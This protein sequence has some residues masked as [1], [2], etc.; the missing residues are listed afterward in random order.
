MHG[1]G[2]CLDYLPRACGLYVVQVAVMTDHARAFAP[3]LSCCWVIRLSQSLGHR[4]AFGRAVY[5]D[6]T[7][8]GFIFFRAG[9]LGVPEGSR[10]V[11][12]NVS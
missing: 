10:L 2:D 1:D 9:Q 12:D 6:P 11:F 8:C 4:R 3:M 5:R 7:R